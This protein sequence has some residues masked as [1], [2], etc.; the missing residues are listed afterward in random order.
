MMAIIPQLVTQLQCARTRVQIGDHG[1]VEPLAELLQPPQILPEILP[2]ALFN[3]L[4]DNATNSGGGW[5]ERCS[6]AAIARL[7][8]WQGGNGGSGGRKSWTCT[9]CRVLATPSLANI[10][11]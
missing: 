10:P 4:H 8:V 6:Y 7:G 9:G 3:R 1:G 5:D 2:T 11:F